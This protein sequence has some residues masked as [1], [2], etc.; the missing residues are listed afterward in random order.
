[1]RGV[2]VTYI[3]NSSIPQR[4]TCRLSMQQELSMSNHRRNSLLFVRKEAERGAEMRTAR[5]VISVE[6]PNCYRTSCAAVCV[7]AVGCKE[8][9]EQTP[10]DQRQSQQRVKILVG[11]SPSSEKTTT[12]SLYW[13]LYLLN[14]I[15]LRLFHFQSLKFYKLVNARR[16]VWKIIEWLWKLLACH[17]VC[18]ISGLSPIWNDGRDN[19][20]S[21]QPQIR[22]TSLSKG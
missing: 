10:P 4:Y 12:F 15:L 16:N 9:A 19:E 8:R 14:K 21:Y 5:V 6:I 20:D 18:L 17:R 3:T 13:C 7:V 1:M 2:A 22:E 11:R